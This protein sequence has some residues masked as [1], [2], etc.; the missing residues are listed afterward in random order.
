MREDVRRKLVETARKGGRITYGELM[1][2]FGI[3]RGRSIGRVLEEI[4][5]HETSEGRPPLGSIVVLR[6][7]DYPSGGFL[8][9]FPGRYSGLRRDDPRARR[10]MREDQER[11]WEYWRRARPARINANS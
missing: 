11:T 5:L 3:A 8:A 4:C 10:L 9:V 1:R 6:G 7:G 2:S